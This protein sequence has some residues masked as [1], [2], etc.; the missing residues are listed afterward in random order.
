MALLLGSIH[1][2]VPVLGL[3][4]LSTLA[5]FSCSCMKYAYHIV[6]YGH[7]SIGVLGNGNEDT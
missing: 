4:L 5:A 3:L 7:H 6:Y 1:P 2:L